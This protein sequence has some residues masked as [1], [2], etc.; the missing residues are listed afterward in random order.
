MRAHP[1]ERTFSIRCF[2]RRFNFSPLLSTCSDGDWSRQSVRGGCSSWR[3][4]CC[5]CGSRGRFK[6]GSCGLGSFLQHLTSSSP[7]SPSPAWSPVLSREIGDCFCCW[8]YSSFACSSA[9][10][11]ISMCVTAEGDGVRE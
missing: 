1:G 6:A 2:R 7:I 11:S 4:V 9:T 8:S 3:R 10:Y 5:A